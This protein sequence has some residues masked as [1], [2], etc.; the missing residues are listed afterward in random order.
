MLQLFEW[1]CKG[2]TPL[3]SILAHQVAQNWDQR[4][5]SHW[6]TGCGNDY[7]LISLLCG[8]HLAN[9]SLPPC[10][11]GAENQP[12]GC[13]PTLDL[14]PALPS[15]LWKLFETWRRSLMMKMM[16]ICFCWCHLLFLHD[17]GHSSHLVLDDWS[18]DPSEN[19]MIMLPPKSSLS[20]THF[21]SHDHSDTD[22]I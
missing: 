8:L 7:S 20:F 3:V 22:T 1:A 21:A 2:G 15:W 9:P 18:V 17:V 5:P 10:P 6:R 12:E 11:N 4:R 16:S 13:A 14:A 19:F